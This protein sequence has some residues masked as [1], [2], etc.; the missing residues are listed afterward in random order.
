MN[1]F[2]DALNLTAFL[3]QP[4]SLMSMIIQ[5]FIVAGFA[6]LLVRLTSLSI[7]IIFLFALAVFFVLFFKIAMFGASSLK[8][9]DG[10]FSI[11]V[12]FRC[13]GDLRQINDSLCE[14]P[15]SRKGLFFCFRHFP[16]NIPIL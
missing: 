16:R 13:G 8:W 14:M 11:W 2:A 9:I 6:L 1:D 10:R 4:V 3:I 7:P 5:Q 12:T 15:K